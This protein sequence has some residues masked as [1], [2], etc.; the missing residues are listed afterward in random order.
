MILV[1]FGLPGWILGSWE[2]LDWILAPGLNFRFDSGLDLILEILGPPELDF[3]IL[4]LSGLDSAL[5]RRDSWGLLG[6]PGLHSA[7]LKLLRVPGASWAL[8]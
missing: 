6:A 2:L 1:S 4:G 5:H 3:E 8:F 7:F